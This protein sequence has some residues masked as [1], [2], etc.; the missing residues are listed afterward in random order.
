MSK[1]SARVDFDDEVMEFLQLRAVLENRPI[2]SILLSG[3]SLYQWYTEIKDNG[4]EVY[5]R[6]EDGKFY[7]VTGVNR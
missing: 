4:V 6:T 3:I 7:R 1:V 5:G 2:G